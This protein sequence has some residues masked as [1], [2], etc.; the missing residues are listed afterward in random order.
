[1]LIWIIRL[2]IQTNIKVAANCEIP[3]CDACESGKGHCQ[4]GKIKTTKKNTTKEKDLNK[5][6]IMTGNLLHAYH[7]I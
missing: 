6:H 1:M 2:N 3:K 4:H 7:Y 5:D